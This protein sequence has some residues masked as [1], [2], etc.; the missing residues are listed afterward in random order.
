MAAGITT[1]IRRFVDVLLPP[2]CAA[3]R[4]LV[5][6]RAPICRECSSALA[7]MPVPEPLLIPIPSGDGALL[8][9]RALLPFTGPVRALLLALKYQG[10]K[11]AARALARI[12]SDR[13]GDELRSGILVPIPLHPRRERARGYNQSAILAAAIAEETGSRFLPVLIRKR[14]TRSQTRLGR[15]E[16]AGNVSGAFTLAGP[17]IASPAVV[18]LVDDV[19]TT[20]AT[21]GEAARVLSAAGAR[22]L[23]ALTAAREL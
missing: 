5:E 17:T 3:C 22:R 1:F 14:S 2:T 9:A 7:A 18:T 8:E 20:G 15:K 23:Q 11:D 4:G 21:L 19:V 16:R 10:R 13:Y 6:D 12:A